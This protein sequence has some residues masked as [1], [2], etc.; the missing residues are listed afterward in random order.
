MAVNLLGAL[1]VVT[2]YLTV[3]YL[4]IRSARKVH[5]SRSELWQTRSGLSTSRLR[6]AESSGYFVELFVANRSVPL[7]MS[8]ISMTDFTAAGYPGPYNLHREHRKDV[9]ATAIQ[10]M[11]PPSVSTLGLTAIIAAVMSSVDSSM[12]S[13]SS[14]ITRNIYHFIFRPTASDGEVAAVLRFTLCLVGAVSTF[15]ALRVN[16]VFTL[17]TL[18]SDLVYVLLFPQF[19]SLFFLRNESNAYGAFVGFVAGIVL[20]ALCG[21]PNVNVP[22]TIRLPLYDS[23]R[24]QQFPFRTLCMLFSLFT[25]LVTSALAA[26]AFR[27]KLI[28]ERL[29]VWS[30]FVTPCDQRSTVGD[31]QRTVGLGPGGHDDGHTA[32]TVDSKGA[33][34]TIVKGGN[35]VTIF[36]SSS[37]LTNPTTHSD[38]SSVRKELAP[39]E[40][41]TVGALPGQEY[42]EI[43]SNTDS[44][45][46]RAP[47]GQNAAVGSQTPSS[48]SFKDDAPGVP[49]V[50]PQRRRQ[51][52]AKPKRSKVASRDSGG[53][54]IASVDR[55]IETKRK[56]GRAKA[57]KDGS[58]GHSNKRSKVTRSMSPDAAVSCT[59]Q[60]NKTPNIETPREETTTALQET[61]LIIPGKT[62][63]EARSTDA[64]V[65]PEGVAGSREVA[66]DSAIV[67][68][69]TST[70]RRK[71]KRLQA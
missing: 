38:V 43:E 28:P 5:S 9:L 39:L 62:K 46:S 14:L 13:A 66:E 2:Y 41:E 36:P 52:R 29:D 4:G 19:V 21:E 1:T 57:D 34:R 27:R 67:S 53:G 17:W 48:P 10:Y 7:F 40:D 32:G 50:K 44:S 61:P 18:S 58:R 25:A 20:R 70:R 23:Q 51:K 71:K 33:A 12:L 56:L 35:L 11:T 55:N 65:R 59:E 47:E 68:K 42:A 60:A 37:S 15:A 69:D 3:V 54:G 24:G 26:A 45:S 49:A 31:A 30:C 6:E 63:V 16:S 8:A 64:R 22:V